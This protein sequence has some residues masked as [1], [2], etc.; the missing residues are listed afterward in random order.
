MRAEGLS[1]VRRMMSVDPGARF[2]TMKDVSAALRAL[3]P[4]S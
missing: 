3:L 4:R 1:V 2:P